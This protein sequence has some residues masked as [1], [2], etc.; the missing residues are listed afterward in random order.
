M[1]LKRTFTYF[2]I[3]NIIFLI[4]CSTDQI[5][6][7]VTDGDFFN[8]IELKS[9]PIKIL[10]E[11]TIAFTRAGIT[12]STSAWGIYFDNGVDTVD[13]MGL[14]P[15]G[16]YQ[17]PFK[18]PIPNKTTSATVVI[19][20]EGWGTKKNTTYG[21]YLPYKFANRDFSKIPWDLRSVPLQKS[22]TDL[23]ASGLRMLYAS[24]TVQA[25]GDTLNTVVN[26]KGSILQIRCSFPSIN[27][28]FVKMMLASSDSKQFT[29]YSQLNMFQIVPD[30]NSVA[31]YGVNQVLTELEH[32][33]HVTIL[34]DKIQK[35][36]SNYVV[37]YFVVPP[38]DFTGKTFTAYLWDTAGNVYAG[39]FTRP[40]STPILRH[41]FRNFNV[42]SMS[43]YTGTVPALNPWEKT[44][45]VCPTCTPVAF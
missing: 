2:V 36:S 37:G 10:S 45:D 32:S 43:L 9:A 24:D 20:A 39:S 12:G 18:V 27:P 5:N 31:T 40:T 26:M 1:N 16:G 30:G 19:K 38:C 14:F 33:D 44:E 13:T 7:N 11:D 35:N 25:T 8:A 3:L 15:N 17:I 22:N 23:V 28:V 21:V 41:T 34:L 6:D 29:T 4:S 42:T